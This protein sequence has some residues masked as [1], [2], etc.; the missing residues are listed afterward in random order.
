MT[1]QK[2]PI[3]KK[4]SSTPTGFF[5]LNLLQN[6]DGLK[7]PINSDILRRYFYMKDNSWHSESQEILPM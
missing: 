7:F 1:E 5:D 3:T 6:F 4:E 2:K